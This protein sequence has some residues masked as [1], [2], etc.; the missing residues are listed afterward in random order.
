MEELGN[1][2]KYSPQ[3]IHYKSVMCFGA[4]VKKKKKTTT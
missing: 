2:H 1:T 4:L 3:G